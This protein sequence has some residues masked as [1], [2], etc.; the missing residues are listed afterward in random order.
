MTIENK[1]YREDKTHW[2]HKVAGYPDLKI[3][4]QGKI[5]MPP[6]DKKIPFEVVRYV[7]IPQTSNQKKVFI[8]HEI[9][10]SNKIDEGYHGQIRIGYHIIGKKS[11]VRGKWRWGQYATFIPKEDLLKLIELAK[12]EGIL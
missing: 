2:Y 1:Y 7:L 11:S 3:N 5:T 8:L 9:R 10:F 4:K 6:D 12:K